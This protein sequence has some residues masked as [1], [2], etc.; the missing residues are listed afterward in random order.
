MMLSF[1][2]NQKVNKEKMLQK[3][4][5]LTKLNGKLAEVEKNKTEN[6]ATLRSKKPQTY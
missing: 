5:Q 3:K 6:L 4:L 1:L 2:V